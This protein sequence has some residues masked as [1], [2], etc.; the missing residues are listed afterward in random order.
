M[1][2]QIGRLIRCYRNSW[3]W[4]LFLI[5]VHTCGHGFCDIVFGNPPQNILGTDFPVMV[6]GLLGVTIP[7]HGGSPAED[8]LTSGGQ[9]RGSLPLL[10]SAHQ[11][12]PTMALL[13]VVANLMQRNGASP[14]TTSAHALVGIP[15]DLKMLFVIFVKTLTLIALPAI[16]P[17]VLLVTASSH[18]SNLPLGT[19][20]NFIISQVVRVLWRRRL[21]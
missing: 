4:D 16:C 7:G 13:T 12:G 3:L 2:A 5:Q 17:M 9:A 8:A 18:K 6:P 10:S 15:K 1:G 20:C 14:G 11:G 19:P 21:Q